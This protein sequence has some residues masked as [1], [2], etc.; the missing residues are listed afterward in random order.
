MTK[1]VP[2]LPSR[3]SQSSGGDRKTVTTRS[4]R[5]LG[6]GTQGAVGSQSEK[7]RGGFLSKETS[8][9]CR[10]SEARPGKEGRTMC[11]GYEEESARH[12]PG[13]QRAS[14]WPMLF[15]SS[16]NFAHAGDMWQHLKTFLVIATGEGC[17]LSTS[18]V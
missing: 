15:L 12:T 2:V 9:M 11:K 8:E 14:E 10:I 4:G 1:T 16:C 5:G 18:S 3:G 6:R 13:N 7:V 17:V